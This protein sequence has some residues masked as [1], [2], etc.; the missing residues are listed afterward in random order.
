MLPRRMGDVR[1]VLA[2]G[3]GIRAIEAIR[4]GAKV[5]RACVRKGVHS[6]RERNRLVL[7]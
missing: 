2:H 4:R 7:E 5:N 6:S 1:I 3:M